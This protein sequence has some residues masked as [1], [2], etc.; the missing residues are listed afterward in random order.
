M[1]ERQHL[2]GE[3]GERPLWLN[4]FASKFQVGTA[5]ALLAGFL[6]RVFFIFRYTHIVGDSL[7]YEDIAHNLLQHGVYGFS[8][9]NAAHDIAPS[10]TLIRLPGYPLFLAVCFLIFGV[11]HYTSI[12]LVQAVLD[13]GTCLLAAS[14]AGR[15]FG[16]VASRATLWLGT[17][18][19]FV[20]NYVAAPLTETLT[21]FCITLA[22]YGL[23]RWQERE[24]GTSGVNRWL[25]LIGSALAYAILLR[26]E[27]GLLAAAVVPAMFVIRLH[28][29]AHGLA[30]IKPIL[31]VSVLALLPLMPWTAR[32]WYTF[33]VFQPLA[34]RFATDPGE[35]NPI[36][37]QRWYRTW[38]VDFASTENVYWNYDSAPIEIADL[39]NRAFYSDAQYQATESLLRQYNETTTAS[40]SFDESFER[41]AQERIQAAPVRYFVAL[42][43]A[44]IFNMT[45]RPRTENLPV[46][47]EWWKIRNHPLSSVFAGFYGGLNLGYFILAALTA[48]RWK[49][50]GRFRP[51]I[52]AMLATIVLRLALLVT[53]DNSEPRYTL[54]FFPVLIILGGEAVAR[55][56]RP[57]QGHLSS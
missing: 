46:P 44:R 55:L 15:I 48:V 11:D 30:S 10:P 16:T 32:N 31:L 18:C 17:L 52:L 2:D 3:V 6:L 40:A 49:S 8:S 5:F 37:F 35:V 25:C 34:P 9:G 51:V 7:V 4:Y 50:F 36:G 22:F 21:L 45:F 28:H 33:H 43:L 39:P 53:L 27:Q 47:I 56:K 42:P 1:S 20:A 29:P 12:M 38:A 14:I 13:L 57:R 26:P 23:M 41:L 24:A 19:P 54:E